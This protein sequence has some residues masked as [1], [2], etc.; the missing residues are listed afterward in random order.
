MTKLDRWSENSQSIPVVSSSVWNES[1]VPLW[2]YLSSPRT[3]DEILEWA[4]SQWCQ[5][6]FAKNMLAWLS[7]YGTVHFDVDSSKWMRG[8]DREST[9]ISWLERRKYFD[10]LDR[11]GP[12]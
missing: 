6:S 1:T 5:R 3:I 2:K 12:R 10:N 11:T 8:S 7:V 4:D 9:L